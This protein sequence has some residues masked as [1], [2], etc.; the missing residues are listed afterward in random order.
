MTRRS[1]RS[2]SRS[3]FPCTTHHRRQERAC[4]FEGDEADIDK[5]R[6]S[7]STEEAENVEWSSAGLDSMIE[8]LDRDVMAESQA[9]RKQAAWHRVA[10]VAN[11]PVPAARS[12]DDGIATDRTRAS[13]SKEAAIDVLSEVAQSHDQDFRILSALGQCSE[14]VR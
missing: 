12:R 1:S 4:E 11:C 3:A 6:G 2:Q 14:G 7:A 5:A 10:A 13:P 8:A 9:G